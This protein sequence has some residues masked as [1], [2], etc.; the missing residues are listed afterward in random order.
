MLSLVLIMTV[1]LAVFTIGAAKT[2]YG[3]EFYVN[4]YTEKQIN[5]MQYNGAHFILPTAM[6][7]NM[8]FDASACTVLKYAKDVNI[9][10]RD[11][12]LVPTVSSATGDVQVTK[13]ISDMKSN[14]DDGLWSGR[15]WLDVAV[16]ENWANPLEDAGAKN[17]EFFQQM[18]DE[19]QKQSANGISC[20]IYSGKE[21]WTI[22]FNDVNYSYSPSL[23]LP[24]WFLGMD[25]KNTMCNYNR[26]GGF[27]SAYGKSYA[28]EQRSNY[29]GE[30]PTFNL[31]LWEQ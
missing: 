30:T 31:A 2:T 8:T 22:I 11:V 15:L 29:C 12:R 7:A 9:L 10:H 4:Q 27:T 16:T 23:T 25:G 1:V 5:C 13:L 28:N 14:C 26:F 3:V 18:V 20:G 21:Q 17:R 24:L 6:H 19:C